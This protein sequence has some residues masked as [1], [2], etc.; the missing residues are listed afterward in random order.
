M[1]CPICNTNEHH[2]GIDS[3]ADGSVEN[4]L[5]CLFCGTIR[6]S[7]SKLTEIIKNGGENTSV[8]ESSML[9]EEDDDLY[10]AA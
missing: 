9:A 7:D 3:A 2:F 8:K 5:T 10:L 4:V 6:T 1:T